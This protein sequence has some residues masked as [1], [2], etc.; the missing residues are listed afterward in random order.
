MGHYTEHT[1]FS[2]SDDSFEKYFIRRHEDIKCKALDIH[3][4]KQAK[5][6]HF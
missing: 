6:M 1:T 5:S 4:E 3:Q 2:L